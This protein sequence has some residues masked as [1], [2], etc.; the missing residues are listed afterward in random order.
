MSLINSSCG[1]WLR[2]AGSVALGVVGQLLLRRFGM[3]QTD[4]WPL[5]DTLSVPAGLEWL[6]IAIGC[7]LMAVLLWIGALRE[8]PLSRAYPLLSLS[9][10]LVYLGAV[11][12]LGEEFTWSLTLGT[13]LV[14]LGVLLAVAPE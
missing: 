9:Y 3:H 10:P 12:W 1:L 5:L 8:L 6:I 4:G 7:Y 11:G 13:S 2:A 14:C